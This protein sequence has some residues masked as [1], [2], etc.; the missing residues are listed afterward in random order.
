MNKIVLVL[1]ALL[2]LNVQSEAQIG[3]T[4]EQ[5]EQQYGQ[6]VS[7]PNKNIDPA[8]IQYHFVSG[9]LDISVR[10]SASTHLATTVYYSKVSHG[11]FSTAEIRQ[12]L[13]ENG[14]DLNW[15]AYQDAHPARSDDK[16]WIGQKG[17]KTT[18]NAT[19][20]HLEE[21]EGYVLNIYPSTGG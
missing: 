11:A 1:M 20:A 7:A 8:V 15:S 14:P 3:R 19:Y 6:P 16:S 18:F 9:K 13:H 2:G 21:G 17:G 5:C 4:L 12:L 10:I